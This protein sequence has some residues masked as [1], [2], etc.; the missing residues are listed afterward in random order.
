MSP[1][2]LERL[3]R[4]GDGLVVHELKRAF[5]GGPSKFLFESLDFLARLTALVPRPGSHLIR[6]HGVLAPNARHLRLVV[7]TLPPTLP[8]H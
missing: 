3:R 1:L 5:R 7:P 8:D 4:D 6:Y 2:A